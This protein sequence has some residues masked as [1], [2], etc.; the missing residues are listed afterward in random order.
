[1][2]HLKDDEES[3][4]GRD[5]VVI[6]DLGQLKERAFVTEVNTKER[7][8]GLTD[9]ASVLSMPHMVSDATEQ[10]QAQPQPPEPETAEQ[11]QQ[12]VEEDELARADA[13]VSLIE[14]SSELTAAQV[15]SEV[16][17]SSTTLKM[18]PRIERSMPPPAQRDSDQMLPSLTEKLA[19][20]MSSFGA[21]VP[22]SKLMTTTPVTPTL[23]TPQTQY[24]NNK[25][26]TSNINFNKITT[27]NNNNINNNQNNN[28]INNNNNNNNNS[29]I[30]NN[31]NGNCNTGQKLVLTAAGFSKPVSIRHTNNMATYA[32]PAL[33]IEKN[34]DRDKL[35]PKRNNF[36][37]KRIYVKFLTNKIEREHEFSAFLR[38]TTIA[39]GGGGVVVANRNRTI[40]SGKTHPNAATRLNKMTP[41]TMTTTQMSQP[42]PLT[43]H[44]NK[45]F[46][47][48]R[49]SIQQQQQ[50][51]QQQL[52]EEM[53]SALGINWNEPVAAAAATA[54]AAMTTARRLLNNSPIRNVSSLALHTINKKKAYEMA[55]GNNGDHAGVVNLNEISNRSLLASHF[56]AMHRQTRHLSE[57]K[58]NEVWPKSRAL[59]IKANPWVSSFK[60]KVFANEV[61]N[62]Y[63]S[64]VGGSF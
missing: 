62:S 46:V 29:S 19:T 47:Q 43:R 50:Q 61:N 56:I 14:R 52:Q 53:S 58:L 24:T 31:N 20:T 57:L 3:G 30:N 37:N 7:S 38:E 18:M 40:A 59:R 27:I 16:V 21:P 35:F 5:D 13:A 63:Y 11:Q 45:P 6:V 54:A 33:V 34:R 60:A 25:D 17:E 22:P 1:M 23:R 15:A 42:T 36:F 64:R 51:R 41:T 9:T 39:T 49:A 28:N 55:N 44:I 12:S 32:F 4:G 26:S 48:P 2:S 8:D 10:Q